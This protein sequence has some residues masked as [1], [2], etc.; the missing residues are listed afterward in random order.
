MLVIQC[1]RICNPSLLY[2]DEPTSG[3]DTFTA[4]NVIEILKTLAQSGRTVIA[5]IHQPSSEVFHLFDDLCLLAD[6]RVMYFDSIE[7]VV[8]YFSKEGY[9]CPQYTNPASN[10]V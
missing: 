6:G 9:P 3:L 5:T 2:L 8:P 7:N 10:V 1:C 4:Y